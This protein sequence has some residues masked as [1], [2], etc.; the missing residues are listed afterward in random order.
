MST[1]VEHLDQERV[2]EAIW[3][4]AGIKSVRTL[5]AETGLK[6]EEVLRRKNELLDEVD[7]L[8]IQQTRQRLIIDLQH[9][10]RKTQEDYESSPVEFKAGLVNSAVASMKLVLAEMTRAEKADNSKVEA[11]NAL[12]QREILRLIQESV[13]NTLDEISELHGLDRDQV[14]DVFQKNLVQAAQ[15]LEAG[16]P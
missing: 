8:T 5:A 3:R 15:E 2:D 10:A 6:P 9:I 12:R 14:Q 11:L 13:N 7:P 16:Q 1:E 4:G